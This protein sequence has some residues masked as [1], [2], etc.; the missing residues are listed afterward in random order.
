MQAQLAQGKPPTNEL[1]DGL[2]ILIAGALLI[3]PGILT[4]IVGFSL[5]VPPVRSLLRGF[6]ARRMVP[7]GGMSFH[8]FG[9]SPFE[10]Q[11]RR[12]ENEIEAEYTVERG[13]G[14]SP[15]HHLP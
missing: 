7:P 15:E 5:L 10:Q 14:S 6:L 13:E 12:N 3:T 11:P 9:N 8:S 2:M 4:D 1:L